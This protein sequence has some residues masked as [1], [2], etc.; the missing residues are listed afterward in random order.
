MKF[1]LGGFFWGVERMSDF[2]SLD[3]FSIFHSSYET[4]IL[5]FQLVFFSPLF[6]FNQF[7]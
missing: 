3:G 7:P 5:F 6:L 2:V 1:W 4:W